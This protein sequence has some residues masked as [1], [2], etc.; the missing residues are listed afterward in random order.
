MKALHLIFLAFA[1]SFLSSCANMQYIVSEYGETKVVKHKAPEQTIRVF[2]LPEKQKMMVTPTIG[3]SAAIGAGAGATLGLWQPGSDPFPLQKAAQHYLD[4]KNRNA[5][6]ISGK[7]LVKPQWE[8]R[9]Q[10][11]KP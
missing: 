5:D 9:Y 6:I 3:R 4:S 1:A 7:L 11:R 8:F 10:K 2:D